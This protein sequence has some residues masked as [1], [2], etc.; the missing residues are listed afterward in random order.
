[1]HTRSVQGLNTAPD[2]FGGIAVEPDP[3]RMFTGGVAKCHR[4]QVPRHIT[5]MQGTAG[6]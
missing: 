3:I 1:M 5:G 6:E 2:G 4:V